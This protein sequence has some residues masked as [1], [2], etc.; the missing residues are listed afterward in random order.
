MT[1]RITLELAPDT[2]DED[3]GS[4]PLGEPDGGFCGA[5]PGENRWWNRNYYRRHKECLTAESRAA[6]MVEIDPADAA[7][8]IQW[9]DTFSPHSSTFRALK[10]IDDTLRAHAKKAVPR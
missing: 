10:P 8:Y 9:R 5:F 2:T 3:C 1:R 6:R 7:R 4:C